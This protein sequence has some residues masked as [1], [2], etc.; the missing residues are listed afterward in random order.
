MTTN[1]LKDNHFVGRQKYTFISL[2]FIILNLGPVP[3]REL[4]K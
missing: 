4:R 2:D 3:A 1:E